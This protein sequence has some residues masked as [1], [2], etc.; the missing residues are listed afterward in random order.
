MCV[1][2]T[3]GYS[4]YNT[5]WAKEIFPRLLDSTAAKDVAVLTIFFGANDSA[6]KELNPHQHISLDEYT[7]NLHDLVLH[8]VSVGVAKEKIIM[9]TPPPLNE[10]LH[11]IS[12]LV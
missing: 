9:L 11:A 1:C 2:E 4:G 10:E 7:Q 12:A 6:M 3:A 5:R 8:A